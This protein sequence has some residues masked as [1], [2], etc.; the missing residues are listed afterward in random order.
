MTPVC[1]LEMF[2]I[3][4]AF[5][6]LTTLDIN[7]V[8]LSGEAMR[9]LCGLSNL[10]YLYLSCDEERVEYGRE[11]LRER[12][13]ILDSRRAFTQLLENLGR[14]SKLS[15]LSIED[16]A[17]L[18]EDTLACFPVLPSL[19]RL[20]LPLVHSFLAPL[21]ACPR[22]QKLRIHGSQT[23]EITSADAHAIS[24]LG[25]LEML[26]IQAPIKSDEVIQCLLRGFLGHYIGK[27]EG[28]QGGNRTLV[29]L[30]HLS[31]MSYWYAGPSSLTSNAFKDL[32]LFADWMEYL[33]LPPLKDTCNAVPFL[34]PMHKLR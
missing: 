16:V 21:S 27:G 5:T 14:L 7:C 6:H 34:L 33:D 29:R 23:T 2:S 20:D 11:M 31:L 15:W 30:R 3:A 12:R 28:E 22:L 10:E 1:D 9:A 32:P 13:D 26:D 17:C 25:G 18:T 24:L 8:L 19:C 4:R